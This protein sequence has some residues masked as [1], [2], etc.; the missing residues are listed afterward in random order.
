MK[1]DRMRKSIHGARI[2]TGTDGRTSVATF[3]HPGEP[4]PG[5][6]DSIVPAGATVYV[7]GPAIDVKVLRFP[8]H[9]T[10]GYHNAP[11]HQHELI[12]VID[13]VAAGGC[14]DDTTYLLKP[15]DMA[16]IE[17]PTGTGHTLHDEGG[18]GFAELVVTMPDGE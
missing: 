2:L 17:D 5:A 11:P 10:S 1:T 9:F 16:M 8:A 3:D 18:A 12:F 13:G 14:M 7:E 6:A 4:A 15:G